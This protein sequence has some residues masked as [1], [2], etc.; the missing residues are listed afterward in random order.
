MNLI[1]DT[2]I[3]SAY[4]IHEKVNGSELLCGNCVEM[5]KKLK[6]VLMEFSLAQLIIKC[7]QKESNKNPEYVS[8]DPFLS[9]VNM[10]IQ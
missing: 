6:E 5:D 3:S 8:I 1:T 7:C 9:T 10:R 2:N 4:I